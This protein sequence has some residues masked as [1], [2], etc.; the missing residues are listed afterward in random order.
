M[1]DLHHQSMDVESASFLPKGARER[2]SGDDDVFVHAHGPK[3][4]RPWHLLF[5]RLLPCALLLLT[6]FGLGR[7]SSSAPPEVKSENSSSRL[8]SMI[9]HGT[10]NKTPHD[11]PF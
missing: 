5:S 11:P 6:S 3:Q 4:W 1:A 9:E 8:Q 10:H 7:Y 2:P